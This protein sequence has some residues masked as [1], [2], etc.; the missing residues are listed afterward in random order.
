MKSKIIKFGLSAFFSLL[1]IS[2]IF[3]SGFVVGH[4]SKT[5]A[6]PSFWEINQPDLEK[7]FQPYM[8]AWT[9]VHDQYIEDDIDDFVL[10]QESIRGM[11]RGLG[12]IHSSYMNPD[13]YRRY[14]TP[15]E[16]EYTGI[17]AWVDTSGDFLTITNPILGSPAEE[18]GLMAGDIIIALDS[19]DVTGTHPDLIYKELLGPAGSM[20]SITI[21]RE[22]EPKPLTFEVTRALISIPSITSSLLKENIAYI[23]LFQF[24]QDTDDE[25]RRAYKEMSKNN[26]NGLIL[27]MRGNL[28]GLLDTAIQIASEFISSGDILIQESED[29]SKEV[30]SALG[31]GIAYEI[32]LVVLVDGGSASASEI[33]A[34][35]IQDHQRGTLVGTT[36]Y[37]KGSVQS[38]IP[39]QGDNGALRITIA[40][41]LTP[42]GRQINL[43]GLAP[44]FSIEIT[45]EDIQSQCDPQILKAIELLTD[46]SGGANKK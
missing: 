13:E 19:K 41:W 1:F 26:P 2:V 39:L 29:G 9:I 17:G 35:A 14:N 37:G 42:K 34:G 27:D 30:F 16:G 7:L 25:F 44:D 32:P 5:F 22:G 12:D 43:V 24:S 20:I 11:V 28:G 10:M 38:W 18:A 23:Q 31:D 4:Y 15:L 33:V 40:R 8:E 3:G 21:L 46:L 36:T 6:L 45:P